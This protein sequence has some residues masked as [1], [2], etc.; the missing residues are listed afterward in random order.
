MKPLDNTIQTTIPYRNKNTKN[1]TK[2]RERV[3]IQ[4]SIL[5]FYVLSLFEKKVFL[6][7]LRHRPMVVS[8]Y[9]HGVRG[10]GEMSLFLM[11]KRH[12]VR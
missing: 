12:Y 5:A 4:S 7:F 6:V 2:P 11:D 8:L 9:C 3:I 10:L 1:I